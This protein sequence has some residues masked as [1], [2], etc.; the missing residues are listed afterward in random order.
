MKA[1]AVSRP[2]V[3][4][5]QSNEAEEDA[6]SE[7]QTSATEYD[8][9]LP[10]ARVQ[11]VQRYRTRANGRT[12]A[13]RVSRP[14]RGPAI[15]LPSVLEAG[16]ADELGAPEKT[17]KKG[18]KRGW[19]CTD[20]GRRRTHM[21]T[22]EVAENLNQYPENERFGIVGRSALFDIPGFDIIEDLIPGKKFY[23]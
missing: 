1:T 6:N 2:K 11:E 19:P 23:F 4:T 18:T 12:A 20:I 9:D 17:S 10:L 14:R 3:G 5:I 21:W 7:Q 8:E 15:N 16:F 22:K 13:G